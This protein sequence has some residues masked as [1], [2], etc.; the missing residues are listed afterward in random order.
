MG[1]RVVMKLKDINKRRIKIKRGEQKH[2]PVN[3]TIKQKVIE[4]A[5][6]NETQAECVDRVFETSNQMTELLGTLVSSLEDTPAKMT[7]FLSSLPESLSNLFEA[8]RNEKKT[9]K[10]R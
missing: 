10:K 6:A 8:I 4:Q 9:K 3:E 1:F 2:I 5:S 7:E